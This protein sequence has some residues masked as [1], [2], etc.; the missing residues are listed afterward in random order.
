MAKRRGFP[1]EERVPVRDI[2]GI[3]LR[4]VPALLMPAV[5]LVGIYGGIATP[6]EA[7]ALAAAYAFVI[8]VLRAAYHAALNS[9]RA[10][11]AIGLLIAGAIVFSYV[12]TIEKVP[13]T[14]Q[15]LLVGLDLSPL[16]FILIVNVI[17][18]LLGCV[19]EGT[20][21]LLVVVPILIPTAKALGIDLVHF[22]VMAVVNVMI[23]LVT[24]PFGL[25]LF[26]VAA[27][28]RAPVSAII[29]DIWPFIALLIVALF[30]IAL[31]PGVV[32]W[33]PRMFGYTG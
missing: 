29:R 20:T 10:A 2:P 15:S 6:T 9:A 30:V 17:L 21:I 12:V 23:G 1:V 16:G 4:S 26:V 31:V 11:G 5:L 33:L 32:L 27:I 8:S 25:L 14:V 22:G 7:A 18:L 19:L 28:T 3:T 13:L 24:P